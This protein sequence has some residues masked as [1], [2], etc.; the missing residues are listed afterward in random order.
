[1]A[2]KIGV[3][4]HSSKKFKEAAPLDEDTKN[5]NELRNKQA[6]AEDGLSQISE[7]AEKVDKKIDRTNRQI[8][9]LQKKHDDP[10]TDTATKASLQ[11]QINTKKARL[12]SLQEQK[13]TVDRSYDRQKN[14][15][16]LASKIADRTSASIEQKSAAASREVQTL[17]VALDITDS[18]GSILQ[19]IGKIASVS[20]FDSK[21]AAAKIASEMAAYMVNLF[22]SYIQN[23]QK[24]IGQVM[25][26][27]NSVQSS[28]NASIQNADSSISYAVRPG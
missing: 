10:T 4:S 19:N 21:A 14:K 28:C 15:Y 27:M 3:T 8:S 22:A 5:F 7:R 12:D 2:V 24:S 11:E 9:K 16:E 25:D 26:G 13:N 20:M 17:R 6:S 18:S 23:S 1:M